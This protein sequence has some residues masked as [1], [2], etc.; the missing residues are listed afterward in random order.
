MN[1]V[2]NHQY[3]PTWGTKPIL[4]KVR[5]SGFVKG[6]TSPSLVNKNNEQ[7]IDKLINNTAEIVVK[8]NKIYLSKQKGEKV[9][10][11]DNIQPNYL[12][13]EDSL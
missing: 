5:N 9:Q 6:I 8:N 1:E 12:N 11:M 7:L 10:Q 2:V 4:N 3:K 13:I